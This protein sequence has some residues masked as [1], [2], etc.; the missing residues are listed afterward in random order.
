MVA[1]L[2]TRV[3]G[4]LRDRLTDVCQHV[5]IPIDTAILIKYTM[6]AVFRAGDY[7]IR[8]AHGDQARTLAQRTTVLAA[9]LARRNVPTIRLAADLAP[10]PVHAGDWVATIWQYIPTAHDNPWPVDLAVPLHALHAVDRFDTPLPAWDPVAKI[11]RRITNAAALPAAAATEMDEWSRAELG[12]PAT[13]LLEVLY[14]WCDDIDRQ[15]PGI[16]WHLPAGP[17][18][19]DAHTGN[20]LLRQV[21]ARP[22]ADPTALLCDL[23]GLS[24]GP[25]EWDLVPTAHGTTRFGRSQAA[26]DAFADAYGFDI[27][28]WNGWPLLVRLRELQLVTSV[29]DSF[30][31]RPAVANELALRLRSLVADD[32]TVGWTRYH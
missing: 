10:A 4:E 17:L 13:R 31:G 28:T 2:S 20:L 15:L 27:L 14:S 1:S 11:H 3:E 12:L 9:E 7:V 23:D 18:H 26:Y 21:P 6:N 16:R 5:G 24:E 19:G 22:A 25:R 29:I 8:L 32:P 30:T